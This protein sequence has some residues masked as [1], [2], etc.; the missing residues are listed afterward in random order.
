MAS[1]L[2][3]L[4]AVRATFVG[5]SLPAKVGRRVIGAA[6]FLLAVRAV[7]DTPFKT[8]ID[9]AAVGL[10]YGLIAVGIILIYRTNRIINFAAAG[11]G[12]IPAVTAALLQTKHGMPYLLGIPI[13]VVGGLLLGGAVDVLIIRRF[14]T[15]PR[16]ILTVATL[17]VVQI[18]A[19]VAIYIPIWMGSK[20]K[21]VSEVD[22]PWRRLFT[23]HDSHGTPI[24]TGDQLFALVIVVGLG[25]GLAAFFRF[26]RMGIALRAS[27]ENADRASLLGIPVRRVG[28]VAWM[29]AGLLSAVTIFL[30]A[31]LV[32]VPTDGTLGFGVLLYTLA[33]AVMAGMEDIP[34][35]IM[36]GMGLGILEAAS[37]RKAGQNDLASALVLLVVLGALLLQRRTVSRAQDT[38]VS[39]WQSVKE[40]RPIPTE[41]RNVREIVL[42]KTVLGVLVAAAFLAAPYIVTE[43]QL[44]KLTLIPLYGIVA[45][46][47]VVL[48]GWAG[49][50]SLGQFGIV[51]ISAAVAGGLVANHNADFFVA[52][53]AGILAGVVVAVAIG[54]PAVRVQGLYLAV[55]TLAFGGACEFYLLKDK[56]VLGTHGIL[57]K[58]EAVRIARPLM[59]ERLDLTDDRAFYYFCLVFL[60]G[61]LL[62][63]R[64]FRRNRSGRVLIAARDNG[65]AAPAYAI[66]LART[67]LAAFA[68]SGSIAAVAGVL[69]AYHQRAID[70]ASYG[71]EPSITIF[72][73][74]V[75]GGLTSL[76]GAVLGVVFFQS[77]ENFITPHFQGASLL[78][79]GPGL[80]LILMFLPGG[81]A[82]AMYRARDSVLR[83]VANRNGIHVPSLVADKR[84]EPEEMEEDVVS[85]AEHSVETVE[86]FD[87]IDRPTIVCP[88]CGERFLPE[89][90]VGHEHFQ[91]VDA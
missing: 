70:A 66:N 63:A 15:A 35:A 65:R 22:T 9:G 67:R 53:G 78:A 77:I 68:V 18:L 52:M 86:S 27:A 49:Q 26:T 16:L 12:A 80:L 14:A 37:V 42:G 89:D 58:G 2:D 60:V 47:L 10:L 81:F 28:T 29:L 8:Y 82:E 39:T 25:L 54:I 7:F 46:S 44:N 57:P 34:L 40:F 91:A 30:R 62:A 3:R 64:S 90:A 75:I 79:T 51:G 45:I 5:Q 48:T 73:V 33:A 71:I 31:P 1:A 38:G 83:W 11:L 88:V 87:V 4:G 43:G 41:L 72:L 55:T 85:Q 76:S 84:V 74:V 20:G 56:Y 36:A 23:L 6:A 32:G 19:F 50:I 69:F 17:G 21:A 24:L 61:A 59:F 13:V